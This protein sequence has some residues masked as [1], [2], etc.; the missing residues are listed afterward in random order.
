MILGTVH[1]VFVDFLHFLNWFSI[2]F[3]RLVVENQCV[4]MVMFIIVSC[5][6]KSSLATILHSR[7]QARKFN[8][9]LIE[10]RVH[11]LRFFTQS[12]SHS[13]RVLGEFTQ[14]D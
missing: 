7:S 5:A 6:E 12:A 11:M 8:F 2:G 13:R 10:T 4:R 9:Q 3:V 1:P 14:G